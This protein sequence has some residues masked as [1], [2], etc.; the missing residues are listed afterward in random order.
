MPDAT[1]SLCVWALLSMRVGEVTSQH[2]MVTSHKCTLAA[3]PPELLQ[4][5]AL[6]K[7]LNPALELRYFSDREMRAFVRRE[8][9]EFCESGEFRRV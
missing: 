4:S 9:G 7:R 3:C 8:C 2:H 6:W 5:Y 1:K